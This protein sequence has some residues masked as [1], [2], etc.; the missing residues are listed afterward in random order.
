MYMS[1]F[2]E[3]HRKRKSHK[4]NILK[5]VTRLLVPLYREPLMHISHFISLTG[6]Y[7]WFQ[8]TPSLTSFTALYNW[9][10]DEELQEERENDSKH[11]SAG[12]KRLL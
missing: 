10:P 6:L 1:I 4:C 9:F 5:K 2:L 8:L 7:N 11:I 3:S 12:V